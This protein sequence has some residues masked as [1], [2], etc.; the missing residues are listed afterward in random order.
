MDANIQALINLGRAR[1]C[2]KAAKETRELVQLI[3][4]SLFEDDYWLSH[5]IY[6]YMK[7]KCEWSGRCFESKPCGRIDKIEKNIYCSSRGNPNQ[8]CFSY[9]EKTSG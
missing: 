9:S 2:N 8:L 4:D 1:L 5:V 3:A 6:N 7:P